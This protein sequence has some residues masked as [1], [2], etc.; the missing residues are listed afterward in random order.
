MTHYPPH[1]R[2]PTI[3]QVRRAIIEETGIYGE[4]PESG[5]R[6]AVDSFLKHMAVVVFQRCTVL[7]ADDLAKAAGFLNHSSCY[8]TRQT[9]W[10]LARGPQGIEMR[11]RIIAR[12][13]NAASNLPPTLENRTPERVLIARAELSMALKDFEPCVVENKKGVDTR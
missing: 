3:E 8:D 9:P 7:A 1:L 6:N 10:R 11:D 2:R 5:K 13:A 12:L 4:W